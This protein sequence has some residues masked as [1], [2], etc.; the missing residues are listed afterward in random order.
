MQTISLEKKKRIYAYRIG[1][2]HRL[3]RYSSGNYIAKVR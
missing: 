1:R 3:N 2:C